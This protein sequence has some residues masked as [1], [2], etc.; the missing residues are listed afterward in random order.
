MTQQK[1]EK[2]KEIRELAI[3]T[4]EGRVFQAEGKAN[5]ITIMWT[6]VFTFEELQRNCVVIRTEKK[7]E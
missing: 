1:A 7:G 3:W 6:P 4:S 2:V 5:A